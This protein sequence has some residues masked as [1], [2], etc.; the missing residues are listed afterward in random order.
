MMKT[1]INQFSPEEITALINPVYFFKQLQQINPKQLALLL[2]KTTVIDLEPSEV[3]IE[4]G[5]HSNHFYALVSGRLNVYADTVQDDAIGWIAPGQIIGALSLLNKQPRSATLAAPNDKTVRLLETDFA[6]FGELMDF[7][8]I[9]LATKLQF[10]RD[11]VETTRQ[12]LEAYK[13]KTKDVRLTEELG[14][15]SRYDGKPDSEE[16][17]EF[18][19][20]Y[21]LGLSW[22]LTSWNETV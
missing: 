10:Y 22:L 19:A 3:V 7:S 12:K 20:E 16:E 6:I 1:S 4:K 15:F 2:E 11:A 21:I 18:M 17:L 13:L 8:Q 14:T 9:N 5:E